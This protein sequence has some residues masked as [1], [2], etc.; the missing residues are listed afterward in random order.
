MEY[1]C[2]FFDIK[3]HIC[4]DVMHIEQESQTCSCGNVWVY[5]PD[6]K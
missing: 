5:E 2:R 1:F 4:G 3:C 6:E